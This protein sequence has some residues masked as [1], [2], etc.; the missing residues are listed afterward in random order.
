MNDLLNHIEAI[1]KIVERVKKCLT[2]PEIVYKI[3]Y[4]D[5]NGVMIDREVLFL[6]DTLRYGT[7]EYYTEP[8]WLVKA[9]DREP[10]VIREFS[11]TDISNIVPV[12]NE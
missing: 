3:T 5:H 7:N 1:P 4:K 12:D 2:Y 10:P 9:I 11:V 6:V 8:G